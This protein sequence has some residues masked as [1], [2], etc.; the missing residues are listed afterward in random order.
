M[1]WFRE[2]TWFVVGFFAFNAI[3]MFILGAKGVAL[4]FM[5]VSILLLIGLY[6][7]YKASKKYDDERKL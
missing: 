7:A 4:F 3:A 5:L 2:I 6:P 1:L